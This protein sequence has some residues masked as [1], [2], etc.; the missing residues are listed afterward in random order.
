MYLKKHLLILY[1]FAVLTGNIQRCVLCMTREIWSAFVGLIKV[2][3]SPSQILQGALACPLLWED[4]SSPRQCKGRV[5][6]VFTDKHPPPPHQFCMDSKATGAVSLSPD[7]TVTWNTDFCKIF[8][9]HFEKMA[10]RPA[11]SGRSHQ[12]G[13]LPMVSPKLFC[14]QSLLLHGLSLLSVDF[15]ET[16]PTISPEHRSSCFAD[17]FPWSTSSRLFP[18]QP[19]WNLS[20]CLKMLSIQKSR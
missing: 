19:S 16:S 12:P 20:P 8:L 14:V 5:C 6:P 9:P 13:L 1:L 17:I 18:T 4:E 15:W 10:S 11:T 7:K 2:Q 3:S